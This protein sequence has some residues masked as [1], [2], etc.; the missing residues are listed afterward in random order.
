[1]PTRQLLARRCQ[2]HPM[3]SWLLELHNG[4]EAQKNPL[5]ELF[6]Y[7]LRI[8]LN[9]TQSVIRKHQFIINTSNFCC[10]FEAETEG[11]DTGN[12]LNELPS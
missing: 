4:V 11:I 9:E 12:K 6:R 5:R 8:W 1:M 10:C 7:S 3:A 2:S